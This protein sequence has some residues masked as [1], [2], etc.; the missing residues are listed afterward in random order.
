ME[1]PAPSIVL[2]LDHDDATNVLS[3]VLNLKSFKVFK[4]KSPEDCLSQ[5]NK[6]QGKIDAVLIKK[7]PAI[8]K[9]YFVVNQIK[10]ISPNIMILVLADNVNEDE[11]LVEHGV[12]QYF[13]T[14]LSPENLADK[15]LVA[16]ARNDLKK[17]KERL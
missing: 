10:K 14:P 6:V 11:C 4:C 3:G 16:L 17:V 1:T 13:L 9:D 15:I 12:H 8:K 7:E 5:L 2:F